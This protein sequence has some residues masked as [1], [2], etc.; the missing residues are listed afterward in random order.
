MHT[1]YISWTIF[2]FSR[3]K[4]LS[5]VTY[6]YM[7]EEK[8]TKKNL[9]KY[10]CLAA[11]T[12]EW[13][14]VLFAPSLSRESHWHCHLQLIKAFFK[15]VELLKKKNILQSGSSVKLIELR[16]FKGQ[17]CAWTCIIVQF[18]MSVSRLEW[19]VVE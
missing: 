16:H 10:K 15:G 14:N 13:M 12:S 2:S 5:S 18:V 8:T 3:K 7:N 9:W 19:T 11:K 4:K 6:S 1:D 17:W